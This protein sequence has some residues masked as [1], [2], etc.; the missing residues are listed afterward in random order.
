[1]ST[2]Y[3]ENVINLMI[4]VLETNGYYVSKNK[5]NI[6]LYEDMHI[7][8]LANALRKRLLDMF[9]ELRDAFD[10]EDYN[11]KDLYLTIL[12]NIEVFNNPYLPTDIVK[13]LIYRAVQD[14]ISLTIEYLIDLPKEYIT[15]TGRTLTVSDMSDLHIYKSIIQYFIKELHLA[16]TP[17]EIFEIVKYVKSTDVNMCKMID[18]L[19]KR[20]N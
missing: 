4:E 11:I 3:G 8:H 19:N 7:N 18:E 2:I 16:K 13:H 12:K 10:D 17:V 5:Q 1:M 14:E 6:F 9:C 20:L 15:I